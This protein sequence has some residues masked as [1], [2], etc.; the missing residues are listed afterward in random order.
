[1][2]T[3][4]D[5]LNYIGAS[6]GIT[7]TVLLSIIIAY[8]I[9]TKCTRTVDGH[10]DESKKEMKIL[11]YVNVISTLMHMIAVILGVLVTKNDISCRWRARLAVV[12]FHISRCSLFVIFVRRIQIA[13]DHPIFRLNRIH[14]YLLYAIIAVYFFPYVLYIDWT[15]VDSTYH[16]EFDGCFTTFTP[17]IVVIIVFLLDIILSMYCLILFIRPLVKMAKTRDSNNNNEDNHSLTLYYIITKYAV[18]STLATV[19]SIIYPVLLLAFGWGYM[20]GFIDDF[21]NAIVVLLLHPIHEKYYMKICGLFHGCC[22]LTFKLKK[23][24]IEQQM[25]LS[26]ASP[27]GVSTNHTET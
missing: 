27:S 11:I 22:M 13:Y 26:S 20:Y 7:L 17:G 5:I 1:M 25:E 3:D 23:K 9:D 8:D 6:I 21:I 18:L 4:H 2:V 10:S 24:I 12:V 14:F 15:T 19:S 16:K